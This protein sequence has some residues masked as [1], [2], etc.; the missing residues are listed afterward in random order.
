MAKSEQ[1]ISTESRQGSDT[2][3][4]ELVIEPTRGWVSLRVMEIWQYRELLFFLIWRDLKVRYKQTALGISWIVL[5]PVLSVAIFSVIFGYLLKVP[6]YGIPYPVFAYAALLPWN[7]FANSLSQSS[8][9]LVDSANLIT[10]IYFPRMLIPMTAVVS[11]L[12]DFVISFLVL[13]V[14]MM[15]YGFF[16]SVTVV[17]LP[18][19]LILAAFTSLGFSLWLSALNIQYRDVKYLVPFLLQV[20]FYA[21]PIIYGTELIPERFRFVLNINPMVLVVEG[22]RWAL[23]QGQSNGY[24]ITGLSIGISSATTILVFFSGL[25]YFHRTERTFADIV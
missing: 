12:V 22:F 4:Y 10:K 16:P 9:S 1:I 8:T 3:D 13:T 21:T 23:L 15:V 5:Q 25:I 24:S 2:A 17:F 11:G 20:W 19:F 6:S 14:L 18:L 7:Y